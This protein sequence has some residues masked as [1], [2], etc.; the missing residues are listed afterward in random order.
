M[1]QKLIQL[2]RSP[3]FLSGAVTLVAVGIAEADLPSAPTPIAT[4]IKTLDTSLFCPII[5]GNVRDTDIRRRYYG[6]L[7]GI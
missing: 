1:K 7:G 2:V 6:A 3:A 4:N 5:N